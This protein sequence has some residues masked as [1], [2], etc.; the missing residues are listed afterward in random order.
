MRDIITVIM[1][2]GREKL[3]GFFRGRIGL[4]KVCL[5]LAFFV[6]VGRLFFVQIVQHNYYVAKA[7]ARQMKSYTISAKRGEIYVKDGDNKVAPIVMNERVW[8]VYLDPK[9]IGKS[10][11]EKT[12]RELTKILGDSLEVPWK[13]IW[14]DPNRQYI[15]VAHNVTF[16]K[17]KAID[18]AKIKGVG[19]SER[20][21]R[22]YPM[23]VLAAQL[24]GFINTEG[25]GSGVEYA[26]NKQLAGE[27]GL[28]KTVKD[29]SDIPLTIGNNNIEIP[30]KDGTDVVLSI[31]RNIQQRVE[32]ILAESVKR[33]GGVTSASALVMNPNSGQI[34]A[35]AN[36]PSYNPAEYT[37]VT[38]A[39]LFKNNISDDLYEPA[40]VCKTFT[41]ATALE[42]G[43][44]TP[45]DTYVNTGATQVEDRTIKNATNTAAVMG[46]INFRKALAYSLNTG[47]VEALRRIGGG[48]ISKNARTQMYDFLYNRFGLGRPTGVELY[49]ERG[50]IYSPDED[51]GNAVRYA[52]MTF[53]QGMSLTMVQVAAG[54]SSIVNGGEYYKPTLIAGEM[55][56][57]VFVANKKNNAIRR[58]ISEETS[59]T[60]RSMLESVREVNGG[61]NDPQGYSIGVK[62]G[63]AET[64]DANGRYTS[65]ATTAGVVGFG[66]KKGQK[67]EYVVLVKMKGSR[68]LWGSE[69]AV[70]AFTDISNYLLKYLRISPS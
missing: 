22:V 15:E 50:K 68:L 23:G 12:Q 62:T 17:A 36:T 65:N 42:L 2:G 56:D 55:K 70:P 51:E 8:T 4:F 63:T 29:V 28:L 38:D 18:K 67:P 16:D 34:L 60:M 26:L 1:D 41:Y 37:K 46:R 32:Q 52:N 49:E 7:N 66:G 19:K 54:F 35:V 39:N 14:A 48:R 9:Y 61:V 33:S 27:D 21:R 40:S 53:G 11:R 59:A 6:I 69:D 3:G 57:G 58:T 25:Q 43:A 31:D 5:F 10:G 45:D 30:A 44:L 13:K 20:S 64:Y 47:S 24:L